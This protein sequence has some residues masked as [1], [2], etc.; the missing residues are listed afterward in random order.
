M[1][2]NAKQKTVKIKEETFDA[3]GAI[4]ADYGVSKA[5]L[6]ELSVQ[7]IHDYADMHGQLP[8]KRKII[9]LR[10]AAESESALLK[11]GEINSNEYLKNAHKRRN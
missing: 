8:G 6:L 11:T 2:I 9:S 1:V 4:C 10:Q 7:L 5:D 3:M